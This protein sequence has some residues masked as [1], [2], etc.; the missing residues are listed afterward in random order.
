MP[1]KA[2]IIVPCYNEAARLH[3]EA[4]KSFAGAYVFL[5]VNDGSTDN[6]LEVIKP[7]CNEHIYLFDLPQNSGKS[8][9]VRQGFIYGL[10][11]PIMEHIE[12]MGYWD[13]DLATPLEELDRFFLFR[14]YF[15]PDAD[16]IIGSRIKRLGST[17]RRTHRRHILG[18]AFATVADLLFHLNCYDTQCGAKLFKKS[19]VPEFIGEPFISQWAFD[20]ELL[21]RIKH[22]PMVE[23]PLSNWQDVD[24]SKLKVSKVAFKVIRDFYRMNQKYNRN[25]TN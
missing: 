24:G 10:T 23:Y 3:M 7:Y 4:F 18:R 21:T 15:Y 22:H 16:V 19:V 1:E 2:L 13:A 6:T 11:L 20:V 17:V 12:W 25:K 5:F 8:E 9:A 14:Q